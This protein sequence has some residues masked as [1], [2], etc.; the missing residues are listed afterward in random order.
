MNDFRIEVFL[1]VVRNLS[2]TKA[3]EEMRISQPAVSKH[4]SELESRY[5]V[6]LFERSGGKVV[7]S[8][9][10]KLFLEYAQRIH[11]IYRELY[12]KMNEI[13]DLT[14]GELIIGASSTIANYILPSLVAEYMKIHQDVKLSIVAG[15][16]EQ[17]ERLISEGK[18]D[19][20]LIEGVASRGEYHY[21]PFAVDELVL[22]S[23]S[24]IN[25]LPSSI[26]IKEL[27][28]IPMLLRERGLGTLEVF[29]AAIKSKDIRLKD[30]NVVMQLGSTE[31]IKRYIMASECYA[32]MS[33]ATIREE[34]SRGELSV[35]NIDGLTIKRKLSFISTIGSHDSLTNKFIS[36]V[37]SFY[38]K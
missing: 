11:N 34:L 3:S 24:K 1:S 38:N 4:I 33:I 2:F 32:I 30:L 14:A 27:K 19:V 23:S 6:Q 13:G 9:S 17:I 10:G 15:N 8:A 25:P 26:A 37:T 35:I 36:Y 12:S 7:L 18:A 31:A 20:G 16:S 29:E 22:V 5:S 28:T 21:T